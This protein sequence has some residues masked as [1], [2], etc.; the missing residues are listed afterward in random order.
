MDL[1]SLGIFIFDGE[2]MDIES[3]IRA[4]NKLRY[5][6]A[7]IVFGL[8]LCWPIIHIVMINNLKISS[9][10]FFGWGMYATPNPNDYA[11]LRVVILDK[12]MHQDI[13]T[14]IKQIHDYLAGFTDPQQESLCLNLFEQL[15]QNLRRLPSLGLCRDN[16]LALNLDYFIHFG[17]LKNLREFLQEALARAERGDAEVLAFL[18]YQRFNIF[19]KKAYLESDVYKMSDIELS[20]LGKIKSEG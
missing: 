18:T 4:L 11:R 3:K 17:S 20:Y 9:W 16:K 10:R 8:I 12:T 15:G 6:L 14:S 7:I 13:A 5:G 1:P 2:A 19:Q